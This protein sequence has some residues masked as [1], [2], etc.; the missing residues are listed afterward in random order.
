MSAL[1]DLWYKKR[2]EI[3]ETYTEKVPDRL[4]PSKNKEFKSLRN[5]VIQEALNI[6]A[7]RVVDEE[8]PDED[9]HISEPQEEEIESVEPPLPLSDYDRMKQRAESGNKWEQY[10]LAKLFLDRKSELPQ[11]YMDGQREKENHVAV[12]QS[13]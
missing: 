2:E 5:A 11:V 7:G 13:A 8:T 6:T 4:P 9:I 1:Y 3:L 12:Y 10:G